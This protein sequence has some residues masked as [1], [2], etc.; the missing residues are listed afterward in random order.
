MAGSAIGGIDSFVVLSWKVA[1]IGV[2]YIPN[3]GGGP[4]TLA[5]LGKH[6]EVLGWFIRGMTA[7]AIKG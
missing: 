2:E 4:T 1:G 5:F 6:A 7:G 3:E